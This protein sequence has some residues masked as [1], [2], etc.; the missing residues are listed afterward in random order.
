ML[1]AASVPAVVEGGMFRPEHPTEL[2]EGTLVNLVVQPLPTKELTFTE[3][4]ARFE[5]LRARLPIRVGG[6]KFRR[7]DLYDRR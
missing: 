2:P 5:E 6:E 3:K 4:F 1:D 7:E